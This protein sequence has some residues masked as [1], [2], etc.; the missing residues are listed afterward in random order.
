MH[1]RVARH[2]RDL[3]AMEG[4]YCRGIG[5]SVLGRFRDHAGYNG[6]F[7][8]SGQYDWHL[9]FTTSE[10]MPQH[11]PD[12]DDLLVFYTDNA[13]MFDT[14]IRQL[15]LLNA[16]EVKPENPYWAEN[17]KTFLDPDG[18]R[19]VIAKAGLFGHK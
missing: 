14:V 13:A 4:F 2:T 12:N 3:K 17:G 16:R 19:V 6:L 8:G 18:F 9:E 5:L 10:K 1:L 11:W 7:I 15:A